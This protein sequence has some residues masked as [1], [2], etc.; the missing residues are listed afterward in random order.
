MRLKILLLISLCCYS[1]SSLQAQVTTDSNFAAESDLPP[2]NPVTLSNFTVPSGDNRVLIVSVGS[3]GDNVPTSVIYGGMPMIQ[4]VSEDASIENSIWH[5]VLGSGAAV[6]PADIVANTGA[7]IAAVSFQNVD[8]VNVVGNTAQNSGNAVVSSLTVPTSNTNN[9]VVDAFSTN[10]SNPCT[11][12]HTEIGVIP[13][14]RVG[15]AVGTGGN[16]VVEW[17]RDGGTPTGYAHGAIELV[18]LAVA[19]P[20]AS[21]PTLSEWGL[22]ILALMLMTLGTLYLVQPISP[23]EQI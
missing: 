9:L 17:T 11:A 20:P 22:I 12:T 5:L 4:A 21:I 7:F 2:T 8:Q 14:L 6:G 18:G 19:A 3:F 10:G 16:V 23:R 13:N 15:S 1:V